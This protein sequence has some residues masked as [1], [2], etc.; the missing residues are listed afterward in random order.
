MFEIKRRGKMTE[1]NLEILQ[2]NPLFRGVNG[3]ELPDLLESIRARTVRKRE[4]EYLFHTGDATDFMGVVLFGAVRVIQE[5]IWG[6][7]NIMARVSA[8]DIFAEAFAAVPGARLNV[9]VVAETDCEVLLLNVRN[10]LSSGEAASR[11][12]S[13]LT[14]NLVLILARK[15]MTF[16]EKITHISK[17]TTRDKLLSYLSSEAVRQGKLSFDIAY[18]RQGLADYLCVDRAAMSVELSKLQRE[19]LLRYHKNHFELRELAEM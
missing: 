8:G 4:G 13:K 19:G 9:S 2:K 14:C 7:R 5:D 15:A 6:H 17:R 3:E 18:D 16:N 12:H 1:K 10:L 11:G